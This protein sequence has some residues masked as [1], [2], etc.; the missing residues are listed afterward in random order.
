MLYDAIFRQLEFCDL[1]LKEQCVNLCSVLL[2]QNLYVK[3]TLKYTCDFVLGLISFLDGNIEESRTSLGP[4]A[5]SMESYFT[6]ISSLICSKPT[7]DGT[8][9]Q[10]ENE[11]FYERILS[12]SINMYKKNENGILN[13]LIQYRLCDFV[14]SV[15]RYLRLY[16]FKSCWEKGDQIARNLKCCCVSFFELLV[17]KCN[18][19]DFDQL[20]GLAKEIAL[21]FYFF[22]FS[23]DKCHV[24]TVLEAFIKSATEKIGDVKNS[25]SVLMLSCLGKVV[26]SSGI[27][28]PGT[29]I[30]LL[31][32]QSTER[33]V[34]APIFGPVV[35][36][37]ASSALIFVV[38]L[39]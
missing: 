6:V 28:Q 11:A 26:G 30:F 18:D 39:Y 23:D 16:C 10:Q 32:V 20:N 12:R 5:A 38:A 19:Y 25:L 31:A 22:E 8:L 3:G 35:W 9:F 1:E 29:L 15:A 17:S 27:R 14:S 24:L 34:S 37:P 4:L 21:L 33:H 36:A 7:M 13:R 2:T